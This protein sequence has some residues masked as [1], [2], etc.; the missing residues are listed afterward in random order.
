MAAPQVPP[1]AVTVVLL[2][3]GNVRAVPFTEVS[4]TTGSVLSTMIVCAPEVPTLLAVSLWVAVIAYEPS[5]E[6][7]VVGVKVHA[8]AVQVAVPF[9]VLA[10]RIAT[11]T[12]GLTPAAVV[13]APP[14][15]VT[16]AFVLKGNVRTPPLTVVNVTVGAA[17]LIVIDCA[18]LV[19]VFVAVSVCVAVMLYVP[20]AESVGGGRERPH[21]GAY[22]VRCRS[23]CCG[24]GD[25]DRHRC[26][27]ARRAAARAADR[28]DGRVGR[29]GERAGRA[30]DR[31]ERDDRCGRVD[32]DRLRAT[33]CT[34][35]GDVGLGGA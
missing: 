35:G 22:R 32:R 25:R 12:V 15:V 13:H 31:G 1:T 8:L 20:F 30:V 24:T 14:R 2:M 10:P 17:V 29:V 23:A 19:P 3:Y 27:V 33:R 9:C 16:V 7:A 21:A 11:D 5:A 6:S 34:V 28:G 4:A 18:P 26:R